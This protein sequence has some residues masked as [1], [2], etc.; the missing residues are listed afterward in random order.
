MLGRAKTV[1][2]DKENTTIVDGAGKK[3]NLLER[4][5]SIKEQI[6]TIGSD[7]EREKLEERLAKL[8]GGVA[9]IK[10]GAPTE[11]ELKEKKLRIEDALSATKA[12]SSEGVVAGG[13]IALIKAGKCKD[14]QDKINTLTNDQKKG[15]LIVLKAIEEPLRQIA[16]NSG[17]DEQ[18]V[19]ENVINHLDDINYG[20]DALND[21]YV[22]MLA[23]G[24]IDPTKV[25][26]SALCNAGSVAG[27]LLTTEC[28]VADLPEKEQIDTQPQMPMY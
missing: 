12:A 10:V 4:I 18:Q 15:A 19:V 2:V 27:T 7:Y 13:G 22:N 26:R 14:V 6:K 17:T 8:S 21:E 3:E 23:S 25:T 20:Y 24:I 1:V 5:Q 9:V 16:R 28:L 11:V